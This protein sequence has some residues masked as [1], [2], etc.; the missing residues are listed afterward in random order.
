MRRYEDVKEFIHRRF[1]I[2]LIVSDVLIIGLILGI[3]IP[4]HYRMTGEVSSLLDDIT[5]SAVVAYLKALEGYEKVIEDAIRPILENLP[6]ILRNGDLK[7]AQRRVENTVVTLEGYKAMGVDLTVFRSDGS[8]L[9]TTYEGVKPE[10]DSFTLKVLKNISIGGVI[11]ERINEIVNYNG[12]EAFVKKGFVR[13]SEDEYAMV[14]VFVKWPGMDEL[15]HSVKDL[16]KKYEFIES[17]GLY[18][19]NLEPMGGIFPRL[20]EEDRKKAEKVIKNGE[21]VIERKFMRFTFFDLISLPDDIDTFSKPVILVLKTY[22]PSYTATV[23]TLILSLSLIFFWVTLWE[24]SLSKEIADDI[25]KNLQAILDSI[26]QFKEKKVFFVPE[27]VVETDVK[28]FRELINHF[29][30]MAEDITSYLEQLEAAN[31]EIEAAYGEIE[32]M[33]DELKEAHLI[34]AQKLSMIAEGYDEI[35]G[36]HIYR[37]GELS[38]FIAEKLGLGEEF[39]NEIRHYAPLHDIGKILVPSEILNKPGKLTKE[40]FEVMKKHTLYGEVLLGDVKM[41]EMARN[42]ALYHHE[43]YSG[44]GYPFG[45]KGEEIPIEARIVAIVDVYDALRSK[46]PYK[47]AFSHEKTLKIILEGDGR[48]K[49][50]DFDPNILEVFRKYGDEIK[51]LWEKV[52]EFET[53]L[54]RKMKEMNEKLREIMEK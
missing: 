14:R 15:L 8:V 53:D 48:T 5:D 46:R 35:T 2:I 25:R 40:E 6:S 39:V 51:K 28:E 21:E 36:N 13:L 50:E 20:S 17:I 11:F 38:A 30:D 7:E 10:L 1:W 54:E 45:L 4:M 32:K 49:P 27:R 12:I 29:H 31:E 44:G 52:K 18:S 19:H 3:F 37:V 43:K 33:Y 9:F 42:I 47:E 41:F 26:K 34:F 22:F 23:F 16:K 24:D